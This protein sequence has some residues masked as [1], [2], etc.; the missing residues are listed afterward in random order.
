[1]CSA[2]T[3]GTPRLPISLPHRQVV[4]LQPVDVGDLVKMDACIL[5]TKEG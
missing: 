4:F 5:Y 1:M 3:E 2:D